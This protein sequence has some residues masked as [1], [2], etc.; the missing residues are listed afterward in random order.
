MHTGI[1]ERNWPLMGTARPQEEAK[2][3]PCQWF[4][5]CDKSRGQVPRPKEIGPVAGGTSPASPHQRGPSVLFPGLF[6]T[7]LFPLPK[8]GFWRW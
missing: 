2:A 7:A 5:C 3:A 4:L 6:C 8:L 1:S